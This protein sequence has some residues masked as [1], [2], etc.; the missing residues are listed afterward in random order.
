MRSVK[1]WRRIGASA[2][3]LLGGALVGCASEGEGSPLAAA[4]GS[5]PVGGGARR[6][7]AT[8]PGAAAAEDGGGASPAPS[9]S[10]SP[11]PATMPQAAVDA[12]AAPGAV[13]PTGATPT[14]TPGPT[15]A[16]GSDGG[17]AP[18]VMSGAVT[19]PPPTQVSFASD[20]GTST[21]APTPTP[22]SRVV[23]A[24][25]AVFGRVVVGVVYAKDVHVGVLTAGR[26]VES[27]D[28]ARWE[29]ESR[30]GRLEGE[31]LEADVLYV[32]EL[33]ADA[34]E[35]REIFAKSVKIGGK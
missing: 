15:S 31:T 26:V 25:E 1:G 34:L 29:A 11:P 20:A 21:P 7:Q 33:K 19:P 8:A 2:L 13:P 4:P 32:K 23:R 22:A 6:G 35:A 3:F 9:P 5:E 30:E 28:E 24:K 14:P 17:A 10:P 12:G 27:P 18:A 16:G